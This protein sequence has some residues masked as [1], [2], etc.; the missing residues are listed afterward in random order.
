MMNLAL[1]L[2]FLFSLVIAGCGGG[3]GTSPLIG[4][5]RI[6]GIGY[7]SSYSSTSGFSICPNTIYLSS[8]ISDT[9]TCGVSDSIELRSDN[10]FVFEDGSKTNYKSTSDVITINVKSGS[11]TVSVDISYKIVNGKLYML[12]P[13]IGSYS[14]FSQVCEKI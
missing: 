4:V 8:S 3:G 13:A 12:F 2:V 11:T 7:P 9:A 10:I 14:A 6:A 5:W 1:R